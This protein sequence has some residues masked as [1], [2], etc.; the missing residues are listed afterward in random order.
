MRKFRCEPGTQ[1]IGHAVLA[2]TDNLQAMDVQDILKKQDLTDV[3]PDQW[4]DMQKLLD[5]LNDVIKR[6]RNEMTNFVAM[7]VKRA[8]TAKMPPEAANMTLPQFLE[9]WNKVYQMQH[10][11]GDVGQIE[12]EKISDTHY[13]ICYDIIYPD[14]FIYGVAW[15]FTKRFLPEGHPYLVEYDENITRKD[16]GGDVTVI[17]ISWDDEA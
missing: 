4:Y 2:F 8:E 5:V 17:H 6:G 1:A 12:A 9:N 10:R 3:Q 14:D 16:Q 11:N 13:R 7:G 15:G